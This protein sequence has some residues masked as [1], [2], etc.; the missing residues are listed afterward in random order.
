MTITTQGQVK[1]LDFGLAKAFVGGAAAGS[2][3][4]TVSASD[5]ETGPSAVRLS[6]R[7]AANGLERYQQQEQ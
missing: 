1:V 6:P 2:D 4:A 3:L 7:A 5:S